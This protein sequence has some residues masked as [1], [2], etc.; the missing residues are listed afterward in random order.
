MGTEI[1]AGCREAA[2]E[3]ET[4]NTEVN[5]ATELTIEA[6]SCLNRNRS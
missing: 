6:I 2:G 4:G 5:G 3:K 1:L